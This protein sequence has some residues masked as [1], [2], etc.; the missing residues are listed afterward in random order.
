MH[1]FKTRKIKN[2]K[3]INI[4]DISHPDLNIKN[5][6]KRDFKKILRDFFDYL[7]RKNFYYFKYKNFFKK[8]NYYFNLTLPSKG[9][10]DEARKKK[11]KFNKKK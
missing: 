11:I 9:F 2:L 1:N 8:Q 5:Y 7:I 4:L 3:T 6:I 10:S